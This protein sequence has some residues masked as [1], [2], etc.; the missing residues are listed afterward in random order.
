M[1]RNFRDIP[2]VSNFISKTNAKALV[3]T[4]PIANYGIRNQ[5]KKITPPNINNA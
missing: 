1:K 3:A 2:I 4:E 5:M